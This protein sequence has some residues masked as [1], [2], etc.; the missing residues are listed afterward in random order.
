MKLSSRFGRAL[1]GLAIASVWMPIPAFAQEAPRYI[2]PA[3]SVQ[4]RGSAPGMKVKVISSGQEKKE[5]A[6][7]FSEGDEAYS[8]LLDFAERDAW[9]LEW[10]ISSPPPAY[11]FATVPTVASRRPLWDLK[12]PEDPDS[13]YE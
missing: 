6:I 5:Y 9:T 7:I 1:L 12:H 11:N 3:Q 4:K 10:S 13:R 8:G 2:T